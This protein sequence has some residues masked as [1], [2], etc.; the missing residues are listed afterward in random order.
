M[1]VRFFMKEKD[2]DEDKGID[3]YARTIEELLDKKKY[4]LDYYQREYNWQKNQVTDLINDL[5][6]K[7]FDSY[8]EEDPRDQV[9][10][11]DHYFLGSIIISQTGGKRY[12]VDGQQ[13]LTTLTLLLIKLH[14]LL[15]DNEQ[16]GQVASLIFSTRFAK[17]SFNLDIKDREPIMHALYSDDSFDLDSFDLDSFIQDDQWDS[18][19]NI[20]LRYNDIET[21][22]DLLNEEIIPFFVD[23]LLAKVYLVEIIAYNEGDAYTIFET[24]N[25]RGLSLTPA[26]M[27]KGYLLANI[28]DTDQRNSSNEVWRKR[29]QLLKDIDKDEDANAIKAWLRSQ[30]AENIRDRKRGAEPQDFELIGTEFHRWVHDHKDDLDLNAGKDFT[31]FILEDF[32]FYTRHYEKLR[33]ASENFASG[34]ECVYY[35]AQND[36]AL[37]YPVLLAPLRLE[38]SKEKIHKKIKIVSRFIDILIHRRIWNFRSITHSTMYYAMFLL[39]LKIRGQSVTDLVNILHAELAKDSENFL[40]DNL[41]GLHGTNR[42]KVH[43]ILARITDYV[44]TQSNNA[45]SS[46]YPEYFQQ[47]ASPYEIEHIWAKKP[48]EHIKEFPNTDEFERYRDRIGGL[49]L[50]QKKKNASFNKM[51]YDKKLDYYLRENSL[52]QSLHEKAY[53]RNPGFLQFIERSQ[54]PFC[55]HSE[56]KKADFD[57]RQELYQKLAEQIWSPERLLEEA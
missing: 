47:G 34:L 52:T 36:F 11:Y 16:K 9:E 49:L 31:R 6:K 40:S 4:T 10:K 48:E 28:K 25:D 3:S 24:M 15:K 27:L 7:F 8:H 37:Q 44:E 26:E 5:T 23:W 13:R 21:H 39:I 17:K 41:F 53:E 1:M 57:A 14:H 51:S 46:R 55:P 30:Y 12:I 32:E 56:F 33:K 19:R 18:I 54:L 35:N 43:R 22:L 20:A 45:S 42:K 29:I 50:L 2:N 38:D